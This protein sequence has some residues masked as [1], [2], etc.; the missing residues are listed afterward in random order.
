MELSALSWYTDTTNFCRYLWSQDF[1]LLFFFSCI[2]AV[3]ITKVFQLRHNS[4]RRCLFYRQSI[5]ANSTKDQHQSA[6]FVYQRSSVNLDILLYVL[7]SPDEVSKLNH[8]LSGFAYYEPFPNV[9]A[10]YGLKMRSATSSPVSYIQ[11]WWQMVQWVLVAPMLNE[12]SSASNYDC[13]PFW[14]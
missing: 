12:S 9:D 5:G 3:K 7:K 2:T 8:A 6:C 13:F 10:P 1:H 4:P 14:P 11:L